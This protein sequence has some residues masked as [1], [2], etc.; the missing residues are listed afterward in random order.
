[1]TGRGVLLLICIGFAVIADRAEGSPRIQLIDRL[2]ETRP[3]RED[4]T[5]LR[6]YL[7]VLVDKGDGDGD[8]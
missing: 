8:G 2:N 7:S 4:E 5:L 3:C 1:M 6:V